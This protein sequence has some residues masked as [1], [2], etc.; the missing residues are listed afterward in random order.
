M[1]LIWPLAWFLLPLPFLLRRYM[2]P[3]VYSTNG[4]LR[5]PFYHSLASVNQHYSRY[6]NGKKLRFLLLAI[7]WLLLVAALARPVYIGEET[8]LPREGRDLMLAI[9]LSGSMGREDFTLDGRPATRL[10]VVKDA[11]EDFISRR[12]GDRLGLIL[13]GD[14]AYLQ[15]PLTFDRTIVG[16]LLQEPQVGLTGQQTAIGDAIAVATKRLRDRPADSRV[17]VLLTDGANTAGV[18]QPLDAAKLAKD[19]GIRIYTIGVGAGAMVVDTFLGRQIVDPS[20][21]LDEA[22]LQKI[23]DITGG[24]YFRAKDVKG[25]ASIYTELDRLEP[26]DGDPQTFRPLVELFYWPLGGAL[27]LTFSLAT[28][29]VL[30]RYVH[31]THKTHKGLPLQTGGA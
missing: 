10:D 31:K 24:R 30:P 14:R 18:V 3:V 27:I 28:I 23:A 26:V 9:D 11:A 21:D 1:E 7:I 8:P 13:F 22:S 25:L 12:V 6:G 20:Q 2:K 29:M 17:L 15:A 16:R 4:T 19:F 5:V